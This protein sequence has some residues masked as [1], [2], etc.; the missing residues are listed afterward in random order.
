MPIYARNFSRKKT[1]LQV[2][3]FSN[4][5]FF[6]IPNLLQVLEQP[7]PVPAEEIVIR[8]SKKS[9]KEKT[10]VKPKKIAHAEWPSEEV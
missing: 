6:A 7:V 5:I 10:K 4:V 9:K 3:S 1:T 8:S 2:H